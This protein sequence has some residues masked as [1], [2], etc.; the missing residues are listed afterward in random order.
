[1]SIPI[2]FIPQISGVMTKAPI[3]EPAA[4]RTPPL[5]DFPPTKAAAM[6][7]SSNI[8]PPGGASSYNELSSLRDSINDI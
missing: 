7:F 2:E 8:V 1:V 4:G 6:A 3:Y 5:A